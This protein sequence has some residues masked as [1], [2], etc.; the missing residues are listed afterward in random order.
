MG[1]V[2]NGTLFSHQKRWNA[3]ICYNMDG[4][5]EYHAKGNKS[6]RK[7]Q[8]PHDFTHLWD[9]KLKATSEQTV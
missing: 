3:A 8:E 7:G 2:Y 4:S 6:D 9:L 5:W 1:H